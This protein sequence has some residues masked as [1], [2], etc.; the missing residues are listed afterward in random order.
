LRDLKRIV[1]R[2]I[3]GLCVLAFSCPLLAQSSFTL[4]DKH[5]G[6]ALGFYL[7]Y[8][9]TAEAS[10][11]ALPPAGATPP[12]QI[13][14]STTF[15][16]GFI[17][18]RAYVHLSLHNESQKPKVI[19]LEN[20]HVFSPSVNFHSD[21]PIPL[22]IMRYASVVG[23]E[24]QQ[25]HNLPAFKLTV[26]PGIHS[27][28]FELK[29]V[30]KRLH[31]FLWDEKSFQENG[32]LQFIIHMMLL[33]IPL[34]LIL[35]HGLSYLSHRDPM[36]RDYVL[37]L[38]AVWTMSL[39]SLGMIRFLIPD[40]SLEWIHEKGIY[41]VYIIV[42]LTA[43]RFTQTTLKVNTAARLQSGLTIWKRLHA[44]ALLCLLFIPFGAHYLLILLFPVFSAFV[45]LYFLFQG[46]RSR[47]T[48]SYYFIVSAIPM[49]FQL[50]YSV[51]VIFLDF[52]FLSYLDLMTPITQSSLGFG[53]SMGVAKLIQQRERN[54][55]QKISS[56][57][58][59]LRHHVTNV[60]E[61]IAVKT[62]KIQSILTH[63]KQGVFTI[64]SNGLIDEE[65]SAF[66]TEIFK[67]SPID[68]ADLLTLLFH[69]S[70]FTDDQISQTRS[71]LLSVLGE[72]AINFELNQS[73]FPSEWT[74]QTAEGS[75]QILECD[76]I[77]I[78]NQDDRS[79][80]L[81]LALRDVT[82]NR[83]LLAQNQYQSE[84]VQILT[85]LL[86]TD[87]IQLDRFFHQVQEYLDDALSSLPRMD[88]HDKAAWD[89][90]FIGTHTLKGI[91]RTLHLQHLTDILHEIENTLQLQRE[92][93]DGFEAAK[94][95][96]GI[97]NFQ[98]V[99]ARY[100]ELA[101]SVLRL[102]AISIR[103]QGQNELQ[104]SLQLL[105]SISVPAAPQE[106]AAY[107]R[108]R[109]MLE[110][111]SLVSLDG[112]LDELKLT[113]KQVARNL[114]K[115]EPILMVECQDIRIT[116]AQDI[117]LRNAFVHLATNA[118]DHGIE[119]AQARA[120]LGKPAQGRLELRLS[121]DVHWIRIQFSDDGRGLQLQQIK[122]RAVKAG[123]SSDHNILN[124]EALISLLFLSG[125]STNES[126]TDTSGRG[127]GLHAAKKMLEEMGGTIQV[128]LQD[129]R[130]A[131]SSFHF[132]I[133]LPRRA[134]T[135]LHRVA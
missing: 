15:D 77:P 54:A 69:R 74:R 8:Y 27:Y 31:L 126:V 66:A 78:I 39:I 67:D 105:E 52:P 130:A 32:R 58:E 6:E 117:V 30:P 51:G 26:P 4:G 5:E 106:Q 111:V 87:P 128:I 59:E 98:A 53:L 82:E 79:D 135:S 56:L 57:N 89:D 55:A 70:S 119:S 29:G 115:P 42:S 68:G 108:L 20:Q 37:F 72:D 81:L 112:F 110:L 120:K 16:V 103:S 19:V 83:K 14:Q 22:Y 41:A 94:F 60:E 86:D 125:F 11:L 34:V 63:I 113:L 132:E 109:H 101:R 17:K 95:H 129:S 45:I 49:L 84:T 80:R 65:Y 133:K 21:S 2:F 92:I 36:H 97:L 48:I 35:Q 23:D 62:A 131:T 12:L 46:F 100:R 33:M 44:L 18:G 134:T 13:N 88:Q 7:G 124:S 107:N 123:V 121:E 122:Q 76:W 1:I 71:A 61:I 75:L 127:I 3:A 28:W 47:E 73:L 64:N 91:C 85:E 104:D 93:G 38:A 116:R 50:F 96:E 118:M 99:A 102:D 10:P 25:I 43:L 24:A 114:S 9:L 90:L 40:E